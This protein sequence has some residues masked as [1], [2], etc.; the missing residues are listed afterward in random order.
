MEDEIIEF[1][2][3]KLEYG[4]LGNMFAS[5]IVEDGVE[6]LTSEAL[7]QSKRFNDPEIKEMIRRKKS[8]MKAKMKAKKYQNQMVIV[9]RSN[10]DVELMRMV[11]KMKFDQNAT[12]KE[13]LKGLSGRIIVENVG[14]RKGARHLFWGAK[15]INEEWVGENRMGRI[16][17][18]L[19]DE[20]LR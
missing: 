19:R 1:T 17:M 3:V 7:F 2:K 4:W 20:Y 9:P 8:P 15:L 13:K 16:L 18:E 11:V 5:P 10:E 14:N 12:L 6:W